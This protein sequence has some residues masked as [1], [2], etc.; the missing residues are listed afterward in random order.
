MVEV[1]ARRRSRRGR[2]YDPGF[3]QTG[4]SRPGQRQPRPTGGH[5]NRHLTCEAPPGGSLFVIAR[6]HG[7][8]AILATAV[9]NSGDTVI[10]VDLDRPVPDDT[11][12]DRSAASSPTVSEPTRPGRPRAAKLL[13]GR[14]VASSRSATLPGRRTKHHP[15]T[16]RSAANSTRRPSRPRIERARISGVMSGGNPRMKLG[17]ARHRYARW[18]QRTG[19]RAQR[20]AMGA[21]CSSWYKDHPRS[22]WLCLS[23]HSVLPTTPGTVFMT[24]RSAHLLSV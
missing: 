9:A 16:N 4:A 21:R 2:R 11:W 23:P 8:A 12:A 18:R 5:S 13:A 20:P 19:G 1:R 15:R 10:R 22:R 3:R 24:T 7:Q 6:Y 14:A 17:P